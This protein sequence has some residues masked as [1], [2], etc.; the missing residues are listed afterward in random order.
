MWLVDTERIVLVFSRVPLL[1]SLT[2]PFRSI[3]CTPMN[4]AYIRAL[5][6]GNRRCLKAEF[7]H[8]NYTYG[9]ITSHLN[10][11][12]TR[13]TFYRKISVTLCRCNCNKFICYSVSEIFRENK[14]ETRSSGMVPQVTTL[15]TL[16]Y[17]NFMIYSPGTLT[18]V[19][20]LGMSLK[21]SVV[22]KVWHVL[23]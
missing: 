2:V 23:P 21:N 12:V 4:G 17:H 18:D 7:R 10:V 15:V 1:T 6:H 20:R 9:F 19:S 16:S 22:V 11:K 5:R 13:N 14:H 8:S 3:P